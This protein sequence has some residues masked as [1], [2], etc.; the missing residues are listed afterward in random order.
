VLELAARDLGGKEYRDLVGDVMNAVALMTD[1]RK[2]SATS[3]CIYARGHHGLHSWEKP[4][5]ACLHA[6]Y[7][8]GICFLP[9]GHMQDHAF[10]GVVFTGTPQTGGVIGC[11]TVSVPKRC[12][13]RYADEQGRDAGQCM[14][15]DRHEGDHAFPK[16]DATR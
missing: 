13:W 9:Y 14:L 6:V 16:K 2:S 3:P 4:E 10:G 7:G 15:P 11:S 1:C 12:G 8:K 5:S